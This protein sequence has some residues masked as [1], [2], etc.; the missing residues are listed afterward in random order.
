M[1]RLCIFLD[2]SVRLLLSFGD[3]C[4]LMDLFLLHTCQVPSGLLLHLFLLDTKDFVDYLELSFSSCMEILA[5]C[6]VC[7]LTSS[8]QTLWVLRVALYTFYHI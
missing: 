8:G 2:L 4:K 5:G 1:F 6:E 7:S 3:D